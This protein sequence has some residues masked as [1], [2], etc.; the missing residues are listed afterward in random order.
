ME[1]L[2]EQNFEIESAY[3]KIKSS[4]DIKDC[5]DLIYRFLNR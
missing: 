4:T 3:H 2:I 5:K 1:T